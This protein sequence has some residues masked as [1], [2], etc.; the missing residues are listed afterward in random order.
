MT[1]PTSQDAEPATTPPRNPRSGERDAL[2]APAEPIPDAAPPA[3]AA[4]ESTPVVFDANAPEWY[5]NRELTW[6]AFNQR[7][8]HEAQDARTPLLERIKF[9]AIVSSNLNE[10]FMK[11]IGGLKQQIGARVR[12]L[13]VDGRSP[14]Q[15]L[16]ACLAMVRELVE[17]QRVLAS[18]LHEL[19]KEQGIRLRSY[20]RLTET[21]RK[22]M[23]EYYLANI[24]PLVTPQTMDPAHPFPFI[25]NLSLNLLVTV[26]Y[27]SDDASGLARIKV[28]IGAGIP[29]LRAGVPSVGIPG[30][31]GGSRGR[32]PAGPRERENPPRHLPRRV[33]A[34]CS[35]CRA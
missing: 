32:P 16:S 14:E 8:L 22:Q 19:L 30:R 21:Q 28:P 7:V 33:L 9:L 24:F 17:K 11:R 13:S 15:Q 29:R 27:A 5:L 18:E 26:R 1:E 6:L 31:G 4:P 23:R 12:E 2:A 3:E 10:F 20:K 35:G 34:C 25:S